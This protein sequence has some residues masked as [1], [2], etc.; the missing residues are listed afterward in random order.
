MA[1]IKNFGDE[2]YIFM[3]GYLIYPNDPI[4][5]YESFKVSKIIKIILK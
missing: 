4:Q 1:I 5:Y 3:I 2:L